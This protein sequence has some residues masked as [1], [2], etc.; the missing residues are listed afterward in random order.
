[1]TPSAVDVLLHP[2]RLRIVQTVAGRRLTASAIAEALGDVPQASLYRQINTLPEAGVLAIAE[3]RQ[4]RGATERTYVLAEGRGSLTPAD[5]AAAGGEEHLR[6][7]TIFVAGLIGDFARYLDSGSPD[8]LADGAGYRQVPLELTDEELAEL[9]GRV[10]AAVAL[11]L[12]N[13]PAPGRRRRMLTTVL[14]P[15]S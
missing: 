10:N 7:F 6:Y 4:A 2:V 8:L 3:T 12:H 5:L 14:I 11:A 15:G 13:A 1:M 9:S